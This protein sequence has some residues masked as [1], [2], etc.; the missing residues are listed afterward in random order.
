MRPVLLAALAVFPAVSQPKQIRLDPEATKITFTLGDVLHTVRGAFRLSRGEMWF[1]PETG[2]A[3]GALV[4]NAASG[5]SG[6]RSRDNRMRRNVL[7][8]GQ[9]AELTFAPDRIEGT[10][11][12]SG[13]ST[14]GLHG[15]FSIHGT[16]HELTCTVKAHIE[17]GRVAAKATFDVPYVSWGMKDP[18]TLFLRVSNTVKVEVD[19]AG[20]ER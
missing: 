8:A 17:N 12:S 1:D 4:V 18:S 15:L 16:S 2:K 6:N 5:E 7:E 9:F 13:D 14:F 20:Q 10:I 19:A 11:N 3:G